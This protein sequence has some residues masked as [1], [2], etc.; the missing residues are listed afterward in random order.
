MTINTMSA[1]MSQTHLKEFL[2]TSMISVIAM[3]PYPG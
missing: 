1:E 2:I 3:N